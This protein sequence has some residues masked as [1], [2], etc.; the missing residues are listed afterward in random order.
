MLFFSSNSLCLAAL[1]SFRIIF[2]NFFMLCL[3]FLPST[4]PPSPPVLTYLIRFMCCFV[5]AINFGKFPV[6][7]QIFFCSVSC[8]SKVLVTH[9]LKCLRLTHL[10]SFPSPYLATLFLRVISVAL[11]SNS[12][13]LS[14]AMFFFFLL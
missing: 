13:S 4:P 8:S 11:A 5:S 2:T 6:I 12:L 10:F 1:I 9:M 14:S 3:E 7:H